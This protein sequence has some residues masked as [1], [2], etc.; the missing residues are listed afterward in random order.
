[1]ETVLSPAIAAA[2]GA[3][4]CAGFCVLGFFIGERFGYRHAILDVENP[5]HKNYVC[6]WCGEN[7]SGTLP[8]TG[9]ASNAT[10]EWK[11]VQA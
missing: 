11:Q 6:L 1:M 5:P 10:H 3:I 9:C 4:I 7:L 8:Y 2:I